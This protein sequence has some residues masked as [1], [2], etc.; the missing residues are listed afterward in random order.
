MPEP[1]ARGVRLLA[2]L[3]C[4]TLAT[5]GVRALAAVHL[6]SRSVAIAGLWS[7]PLAIIVAVA[8]AGTVWLLVWLPAR[9]RRR[10]PDAGHELVVPPPRGRQWWLFLA[11]A[12]LPVVAVLLLAAYALVLARA[13]ASGL[14][15]GPA[16]SS[17]TQLF[18]EARY[19]QH[20]FTTEHRDAAAGAL[21]AVRAE[22]H[23]RLHNGGRR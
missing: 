18:T 19:S 3:A 22:L 23:A 17:L 11:A 4:L 16:A 7:A 14:L 12:L 15:H 1:G 5:V 21:D 9:R 6:P 20:S 2:P 13:R 10:G 8:G